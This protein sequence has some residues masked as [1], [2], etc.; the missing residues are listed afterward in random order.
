MKSFLILL[1]WIVLI[2]TPT[3]AFLQE[4]GARADNK[5][6]LPY[7]V[8]LGTVQDGGSPHIGCERLCCNRLFLKPNTTR[9]R[10]CI[11]IVDPVY[12]KRFLIE[13]TPD[14]VEQMNR[15]QQEGSFEK[16]F[17]PDGIFLTHAHIGHYTGLMYLGREAMDAKGVPVYAMPRMVEFLKNNGPWS[18][19]VINKNILLQE[20]SEG[21][22]VTLTPRIQITPFKVPHRDEYS[23]T[24][25][26]LID[27]AGKLILFIPDIDKWE[28]WSTSIIDLITTVDYAYI[29]GTFYNSAEI[30]YRDIAQVLHP[31]VE[32]SMR[33]FD[34]LPLAERNKIYFIHFNH[35]NPLLDRKSLAYKEVIKKGYHVAMMEKAKRLEGRR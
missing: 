18:Q 19:L 35:T 11:G 34:T 10:T 2:I 4:P 3:I 23:E 20:M 13:A 8:I 21:T 17:I 24:A 30:N 31:G 28:K 33:L 7:I 9:Q 12:K 16:S 32:E 15:F 5:S 22:A 1:L 27:M 29:D 6:E 25:G 26:F 14:I